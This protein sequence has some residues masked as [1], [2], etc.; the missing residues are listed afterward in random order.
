MGTFFPFKKKV[1]FFSKMDNIFLQKKKKI[2]EKNCDC[3]T[4][5]NY[6]HPLDWKQTFFVG[7]PHVASVS[8]TATKILLPNSST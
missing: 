7:W 2:G 8:D 1:S 3:P 5:Q 6:S 4:G